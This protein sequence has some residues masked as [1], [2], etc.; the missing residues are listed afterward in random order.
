VLKKRSRII[1]DVTKRYHKRTPNFGI[2]VPKSWDDCMR[3]DTENG[4][5]MC[6]DEVR[7]EMKNVHIAF[8]IMN[9]YEKIPPYY[10]KI[11]CH[12]IF[13]IKMEYFW[14]KARFVSGGY[15]TDTPHDMTYTSVVS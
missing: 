1:D 13:D 7:K 4:N 5:T 15:T 10:Q 6:Q 12:N 2:E 8:K 3:L 14:C 11:R 9:G